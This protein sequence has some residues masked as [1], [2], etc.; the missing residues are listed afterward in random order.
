MSKTTPVPFEEIAKALDLESLSIDEQEE[1]MLDLNALIFKGT[2]V[3][4]VEAMEPEVRAKWC[5]LVEEEASEAVME[6]FLKENVPNADLAVVEVVRELTS[7]IL[8]VT[9]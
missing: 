8:A 9:K 6:N 3:R 2:M 4:L 5:E 7:D 1:I